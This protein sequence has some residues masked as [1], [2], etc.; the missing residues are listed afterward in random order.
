VTEMQGMLPAYMSPVDFIA[1]VNGYG[2]SGDV[3]FWESGPL[4]MTLTEAP[5][6]SRAPLY[7]TLIRHDGTLTEA[8]LVTPG[9]NANDVILPEA[10]DFD[11]TLDAPDRER[12]KYLI[13]AK[14]IVKVLSIEDGGKTDDGAQLFS[15]KG[16]IDDE[17]VHTADVALLPGP[18]DDQDPIGL[19]DDDTPGG[20][21]L[22]IVNLSDRTLI[23]NNFGSGAAQTTYTLKND[24]TAYEEGYPGNI[25]STLTGRI[26]REWLRY[27]P[28]ETSVSGLF[29]VRATLLA[30]GPLTSGTLDTWQSLDTDRAWSLLIP[31]LGDATATILIEIREAATGIVKQTRTIVMVVH[32]ESTGGE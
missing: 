10:P 22:V 14:D 16:V 21:L 30:D 11:M 32:S 6:W 18:G 1:D 7:L 9:P 23:D 12:P 2:N 3:A 17:R 25:W 29:E 8:V 13:G 4:V 15:L 5:D 26:A 24:G 31:T 19:P 28:Q 20:D 27:T